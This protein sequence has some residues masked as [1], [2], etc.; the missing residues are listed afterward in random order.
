MAL[1]IP[2][3]AEYNKFRMTC[4]NIAV[5]EDPALYFNEIP[6]V[7]SRSFTVEVDR[8]FGVTNNE[9]L[10]S[11][12]AGSEAD[13]IADR[14]FQDGAPV[15]PDE[16]DADIDA[17]PWGEAC[18]FKQ[19]GFCLRWHPEEPVACPF[20]ARCKFFATNS[21]RYTHS[22]EDVIARKTTTPPPCK[23]GDSC[24]FFAQGRCHYYHPAPAPV[25][26][27]ASAVVASDFE[28][29]A[30]AV[31]AAEAEAEAVAAA[32]AVAVAEAAAVAVCPRPRRQGPKVAPRPH[33]DVVAAALA[34]YA[35]V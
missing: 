17:C 21:C 24:R 10:M 18:R 33:P 32:V 20:G 23:N 14:F 3:A 30:E 31:F 9:D 12:V 6:T 11:I 16:L 8:V 2:P 13:V 22:K 7:S 28:A 19:A 4:A 5:D 26:T 29:D 1:C 34:K 27:A 15:A 25:V 35:R